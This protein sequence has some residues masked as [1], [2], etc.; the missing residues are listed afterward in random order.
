VHSIRQLDGFNRDRA[1]VGGDS[2]SEVARPKRFELLTPR[3]VVWAGPLKSLRS[4]TITKP[5]FVEIGAIRELLNA[6]RYHKIDCLSDTV[7]SV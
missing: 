3:F 7:S 6:L 1:E 5:L 2:D 4:V